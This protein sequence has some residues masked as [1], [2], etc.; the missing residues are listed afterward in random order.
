MA[1]QKFKKHGK[2]I[3]KLHIEQGNIF[4]ICDLSQM[5]LQLTIKGTVQLIEMD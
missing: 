2:Y 5:N 1:L 3:L 4:A